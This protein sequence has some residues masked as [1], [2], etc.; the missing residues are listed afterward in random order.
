M[1]LV[2]SS[3]V[4]TLVEWFSWLYAGGGMWPEQTSSEC[5]G[6]GMPYHTRRTLVIRSYIT[7]FLSRRKPAGGFIPRSRYTLSRTWGL[8]GG[9][10]WRENINTY[11]FALKFCIHTIYTTKSRYLQLQTTRTSASRLVEGEFGQSVSARVLVITAAS[12]NLSAKAI[13]SWTQNKMLNARSLV[14]YKTTN[15]VQIVNKCIS[16]RFSKVLDHGKQDRSHTWWGAREPKNANCRGGV[17]HNIKASHS[18]VLGLPGT[19]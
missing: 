11:L 1:L 3:T 9:V 4:G 12:R 5:W 17:S 7:Y 13:G 16:N 15:K 10:V 2:Y 8:N 14:Y 19:R 18:H 6:F